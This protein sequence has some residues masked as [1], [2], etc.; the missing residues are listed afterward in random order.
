MSQGILQP[1][2]AAHS[3]HQLP[4]PQVVRVHE[5]KCRQIL[6]LDLHH[7]DIHLPV[8]PDQFRWHQVPVRLLPPF[9][10]PK[11]VDVDAAGVPHYM[12]VGDDIP[13][14]V[15]NDARPGGFLLRD[16]P[17]ALRIFVPQGH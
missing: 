4:L 14:R 15:H 7:R 9:V 12:S 1:Q 5:G 17:R 10:A 2:R 13:V 6:S 8:Q 11:N 3:Q 16:E